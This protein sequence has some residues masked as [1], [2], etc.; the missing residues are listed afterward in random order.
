MLVYLLSAALPTKTAIAINVQP[1]EGLIREDLFAS[2]E[3]SQVKR[4]R[5]QA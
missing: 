4:R 3:L 1:Q 2:L 5:S